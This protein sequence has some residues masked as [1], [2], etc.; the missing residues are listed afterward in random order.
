MHML[1]SLPGKVSTVF[2]NVQPDDYCSVSSQEVM[3]HEI[4]KLHFAVSDLPIK[5]CGCYMFFKDVF[6]LPVHNMTV[7]FY[8]IC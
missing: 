2:G 7:T 6:T 1:G 8:T 3:L 4:A 5:K